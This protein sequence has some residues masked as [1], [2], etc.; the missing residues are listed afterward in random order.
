MGRAAVRSPAMSRKLETEQGHNKGGALQGSES[1]GRVCPEIYKVLVLEL[2]TQ[3]P[4]PVH[5]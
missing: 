3:T 1:L 4:V 5:H 2:E